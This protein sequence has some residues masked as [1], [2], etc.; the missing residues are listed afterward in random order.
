MISPGRPPP[1]TTPA[2]R[3]FFEEALVVD[4]V[5]MF[6]ALVLDSWTKWF[7]FHFIGCDRRNV[8]SACPFF[9][10]ALVIDSVDVF[11]ALV[12]DSAMDVVCFP[13][14]YGRSL[15]VAKSSPGL[16]LGLRFD[17]PLPVFS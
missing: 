11:I 13:L 15:R 8:S 14:R 3:P 10:E 16:N 5:D 12:L 1:A 4:S 2:P 7:C 17:L 6:V 9:E